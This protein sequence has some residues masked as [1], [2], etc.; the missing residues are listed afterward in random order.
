[1]VPSGAWLFPND[2]EVQA[3]AVALGVNVFVGVQ[4]IVGVPVVVGVL[5]TV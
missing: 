4:V 2:N 1:M 3:V 5:V